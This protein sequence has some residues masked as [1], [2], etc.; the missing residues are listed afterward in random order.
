MQEKKRK[1]PLSSLEIVLLAILSLIIFWGTMRLLLRPMND[2]APY[3]FSTPLG[4][5]CVLGI[6][7]VWIIILRSWKLKNVKV[8]IIITSLVF[9]ISASV[10][11][12]WIL[13]NA[14]R[15]IW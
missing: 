3:W 13:L 2:Y 5:S 15:G 8:K 1:L 12:C 11:A 7:I 4:P 9:T 10:L 14:L 6:D